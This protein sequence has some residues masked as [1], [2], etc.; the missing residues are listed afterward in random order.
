MIWVGPAASGE[1]YDA[2]YS[3]GAANFKSPDRTRLAVT[4][5]GGAEV[6]IGKQPTSIDFLPNGRQAYVTNQGSGT[7]EILD[8]PR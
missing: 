1:R 6:F 3:G 5:Y 8:F 2:P 7:V 4:S